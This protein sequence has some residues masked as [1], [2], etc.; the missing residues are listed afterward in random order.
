MINGQSNKRFDLEERTLAFA[1]DVRRYVGT[2]PKTIPNQEDLKQLVR[3]S[4]AVGANYIEGNEVLGRKDFAM[5]L[6]IAR[7]EAKESVYWLTLIDGGKDDTERKRLQSE[8]HQL[9]L[10][11][12]AIINKVT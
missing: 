10:I 6:K 5:R 9:M 8:A 1:K 12:T 3:S 7:K 2:I 4:G 11:L